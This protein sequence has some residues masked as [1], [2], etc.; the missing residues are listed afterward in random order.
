MEIDEIYAF[1]LQA[2]KFGISPDCIREEV[3]SAIRSFEQFP[4]EF[5]E[6]ERVIESS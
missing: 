1:V 2:L 3:E 6:R 4:I 5:R